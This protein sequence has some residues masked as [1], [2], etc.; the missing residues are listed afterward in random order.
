M[1]DEP[2]IGDL[3]VAAGVVGRDALE[4][5]LARRPQARGRRVLSELFIAG[6]ATE[7]ALADVLA[8][9]LGVP[10]AVLTESTVSVPA[11]A[12]ITPELCRRRLVLPVTV[13]R[14]T[15]T[16]VSQD[17]EDAEFF[18]YLSASSGLHVLAV[19]GIGAVLGQMIEVALDAQRL[20]QHV[21]RG[22]ASAPATAQLV[23]ATAK[24]SR[25]DA[26]AMARQIIEAIG[27]ASPSKHQV[28]ALRLKQVL[29]AKAPAPVVAVEPERVVAPQLP[30]TE[31]PTVAL[32]VE[33]DPEIRQLCVHI[34]ARDGIEV[35]EAVDGT[36]A[37]AYLRDHTPAFVLLDAQLP[38]IHGLEICRR[39]KASPR[40]CKVPVVMM[41][42]LY[43][44]WQDAR[45]VIESYGADYFVPKPFELAYLRCLIADVLKRP[46][47][48][49][50]AAAAVQDR[51]KQVRIAYEQH[52]AAQQSFAA[53]VDVETWLSLDPFDA[54]AWLER[55]NIAAQLGDWV[56]ALDAYDSATVYDRTLIFAHIGLAY[57]CE[58][59]GFIKRARGAWLRAR[60]LAPDDLTRQQI[61]H[62]LAQPRPSTKLP[63]P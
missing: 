2:R 53:T 42:A 48:R 27:A 52:V 25:R 58:R 40:F 17:V 15:L 10:V 21:V 9:Q 54:R 46:P 50:A 11:L 7:R 62:Q 34:L 60:E 22:G 43:R 4:Q 33:D 61:D 3:L 45:E 31:A 39:M 29:V 32:L 51:V 57:S 44:D 24:P 8:G 49:H 19:L 37:V 26:D 1:S 36:D 16:V 59:L 38:G 28:G 35:H 30:D 63:A 13:D 20:K 18:A 41:S 6:L 47:V 55:G 14:R 56:D 23:V 12:H 5:L